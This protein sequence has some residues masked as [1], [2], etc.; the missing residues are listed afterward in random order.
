MSVL[1][2]LLSGLDD[3]IEKV[4]RKNNA[5][6]SPVLGSVGLLSGFVLGYLA[7]ASYTHTSRNNDEAEMRRRM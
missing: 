6:S 4:F 3:F 2:V 1:P 7:H 5:I